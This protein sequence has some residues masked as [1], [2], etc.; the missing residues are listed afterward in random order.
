MNS[1]DFK[2][3]RLY[4]I[5]F[6]CIV[7]YVFLENSNVIPNLVEKTSRGRYSGFPTFFLTGLF[8]YGLLFLG[9]GIIM[10][11]SFF[12]I[13]E[14][15]FQ[16]SGKKRNLKL[17]VSYD[18]GENIKTISK[19]ATSEI[20]KS[21]MESINWNTFHIVQLE[22]ESDNNFKALEVSGSLVE[23]G[24]TSGYVTDDNHL[25]M[26]KSIETVDQMTEI[27][28]DFMKGEDVWRNK[29]EYK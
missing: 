3:V 6:I 8:K 7:S 2:I 29:Y 13:Q 19:K 26:Q 23:D 17:V 16:I 5:G 20:I 10:I 28:L 12:L 27:L 4:V 18:Y 22:D 9:I 24:M 1:R 14:K 21:T 11:L 15:Y 25:L